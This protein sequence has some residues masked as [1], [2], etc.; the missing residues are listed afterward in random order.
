MI[1]DWYAG[2]QYG[3]DYWSDAKAFVA[4]RD[5]GSWIVRGITYHSKQ[6]LTEFV[7]S[8]GLF[9]GVTIMRS[10]LLVPL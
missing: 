10:I 1:H 6:N 7:G 2:I 4:E 3:S 8:A 5:R 9:L